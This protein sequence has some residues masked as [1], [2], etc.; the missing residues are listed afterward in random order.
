MI[1][2]QSEITLL[3]INLSQKALILLRYLE[4]EE[5]GKPI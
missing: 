3:E 5:L 4:D 2:R 1:G